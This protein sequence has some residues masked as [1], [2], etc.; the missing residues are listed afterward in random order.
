M[1]NPHENKKSIT[2]MIM[3][4]DAIVEFIVKNPVRWT[5]L[6]LAERGSVSDKSGIQNATP[7]IELFLCLWLQRK[8]LFTQDE[9]ADYCMADPSWRQLIDEGKFQTYGIDRV[10]MINALRARCRCNFY[11]SMIDTL[12][13]WSMLHGTGLFSTSYIDSARDVLCKQDVTLVRKSG[14]EIILA[15]VGPRRGMIDRE[16]KKVYRRSPSDK[17]CVTIVM[18][19]ER[20]IIGG[21][22][23]Y[24]IQDFECILTQSYSRPPGAVTPVHEKIIVQKEIFPLVLTMPKTPRASCL[25]CNGTG[26]TEDGIP[27]LA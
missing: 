24:A 13:A 25:H 18:P 16:Y 14:E 21:K 5:D 2:V 10:E 1:N 8:G 12:H 23:W 11:V 27:C 22:R 7:G 17:E 26:T 4:T 19:W 6:K 3:A 9:Y 20:K 15:L